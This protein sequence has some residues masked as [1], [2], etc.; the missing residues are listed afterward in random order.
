M[1]PGEMLGKGEKK[2]ENET[3]ANSVLASPAAPASQSALTSSSADMDTISA[4]IQGH[5]FN[6]GY[7][8]SL[9]RQRPERVKSLRMDSLPSS[10]SRQGTARF[11]TSEISLSHLTD[12]PRTWALCRP[13]WYRLL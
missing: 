8:Y 6:H 9:Q 11:S 2:E 12:T 7:R 1:F 10:S 5:S 4:L 13:I 3:S